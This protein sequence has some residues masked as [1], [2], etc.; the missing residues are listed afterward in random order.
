VAVIAVDEVIV[1]PKVKEVRLGFRV[2]NSPL[3]KK[4]EPAVGDEAC[5][6]LVRHFEQDFY[7]AFWTS[8]KDYPSFERDV[9]AARRAGKGLADPVAS[10][11]SK[12]FEDRLTTAAMLINRYR[13]PSHPANLTNL[14]GGFESGPRI[15]PVTG[16]KL[17]GTPYKPP[18]TEPIDAQES[19]LILNILSEADWNA[20]PQSTLP[21]PVRMFSQLNVGP[22]DGFQQVGKT[23]GN[24]FVAT[25]ANID[26]AKAWLKQNADTYRIKR[27][28]YDLPAKN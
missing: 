6:A 1:G 12:N 28:V 3:Y 11:K 13:A 8:R 5:F 21:S 9:A 22:D 7:E 18:E 25:P 24:Y 27:L 15:P 2:I 26:A 4:A 17:G 16:G 14:A 20:N 10:L 19:K 23:F